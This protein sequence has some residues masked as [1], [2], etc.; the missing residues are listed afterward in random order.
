MTMQRLRKYSTFTSLLVP[1]LLV[2]IG[3]PALSGAQ[4]TCQPNGDV[5][6]NGSVTAADALLAFQQA[7]SLAPLSMCQLSV[8]NVFPLPTAPDD[9]ITASDALCIFQKALGLPS[10]LDS[11]PP[12]N[13]IGE[14]FP[15]PS[16]HG[17]AAGQ[18]TIQPGAAEAHGNVVLSCPAGSSA[19]VITVQQDGTATYDKTGGMPA[20]V[21]S[22][23]EEFPALTPQLAVDAAQAPIVDLEGTLHVGSD[24]APSADQLTAVAT[25]N[26]IAVSH[27]QVLDGAGAEEVVAY[28]NQQ[29]DLE[30]QPPGFHTFAVQP[31]VRLTEVARGELTDPTVR[32]IQMINAALSR[33]SRILFSSDPA[34][35]RTPLQIPW[36]DVPD[37][38]I[39]VD[40][41]S[42]ENPHHRPGTAYSQTRGTS[43]IQSYV[44]INP[45]KTINAIELETQAVRERREQSEAQLGEQLTQAREEFED[46]LDEQDFSEEFKSQVRRENEEQLTEWYEGE[47][48]RFREFYGNQ[49]QNFIEQ[50]KN[51]TLYVL[52]HELIHAIG[53][54]GHS[55]P[56]RFPH[57][58]MHA[59]Y[60]GDSQAHILF[61]V[62]REALLA[63]YSV[64][65]PGA[66]AA[67]IVED[68]GPWD[69][70]SFHLR[71]DIGISG[72]EVAF[73]VA[74]RNGL[75]QP[76]A[77][78]PTPWTDLADNPILS[79]TVRWAGRL[80]GFTP[81]I[82]AVGGAAELAVELGTL[83]GQ[84]D[85]TNLEHW[86]A[87]L[88]PGP[89]GSGRTWGDGD[90][91][92]WVNVRGNTFVQTGGDEGTV[93]GAFFGATHEAMGGVL[94][95]T[96]LTAGFGGRR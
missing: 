30:T 73:G 62:D 90:L 15:L 22:R 81:S 77:F 16:D 57:S 39:F 8:A 14:P 51:Y 85:F 46:Y 33:E 45:D 4:Q 12:A 31:I 32:A 67:Q 76:W 18:F 58:V 21:L 96:D 42:P 26:G 27:G 65:E 29:I 34:P 56:T 72:G 55:D 25:H 13:D 6:Q 80:L 20:V 88:A 79:E 68:L 75:A 91:Q 71:G 94:E 2:V 5:D 3:L 38:Q 47:L 11:L 23:P 64:L 10:C 40:F 9:I 70:T 54:N 61:P 43:R 84:L 82:E 74:S 35:P 17:L 95:R 83:D 53:M 19:C 66:S 92:Y 24:V 7:L 78:G 59:V 60:G 69:D 44:L 52:I 36:G 37:G 48:E 1:L 50:Y 93:T 28:L 87:N 63:A 49:L 89:V 41:S 86:G